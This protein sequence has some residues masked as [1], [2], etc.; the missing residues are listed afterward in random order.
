MTRPHTLLWDFCK[1]CKIQSLTAVINT[2][3]TFSPFLC[4][5][6]NIVIAIILWTCYQGDQILRSLHP[7][8]GSV[9]HAGALFSP[10]IF[11]DP[12]DAWRNIVHISPRLYI[13]TRRTLWLLFLCFSFLGTVGSPFI[14]KGL[15]LQVA[16]HFN[17]CVHCT[18]GENS[19]SSLI[20]QRLCEKKNMY[21]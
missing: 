21:D 11:L 16:Y 14:I 9:R 8:K 17:M 18:A 2:N 4:H 12:R 3:C 15:C 6:L 20:Q 19:T 7:G 13:Q 1:Y 10:I 5:F